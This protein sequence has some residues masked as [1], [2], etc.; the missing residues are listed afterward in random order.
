MVKEKQLVG[1][2]GIIIRCIKGELTKVKLFCLHATGEKKKGQCAIFFRK[3][4][5]THMSVTR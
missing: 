1:G 4:T 5:F 2:P 3:S